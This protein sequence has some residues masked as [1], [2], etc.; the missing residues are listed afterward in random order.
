VVANAKI[1]AV[2]DELE[3]TLS[4]NHPSFSVQRVLR[5]Y[6]DEDVYI[7]KPA[8]GRYWTLSRALND[9]D[10]IIAEHLWKN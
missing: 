6:G 2:L 4:E 1:G 7:V 5:I 9:A 10:T 8:D 3:A